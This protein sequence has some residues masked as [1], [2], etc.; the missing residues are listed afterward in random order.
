M[1]LRNAFGLLAVAICVS[2]GAAQ[3][4]TSSSKASLNADAVDGTWRIVTVETVRSMG[5]THAKWLGV[6]PD[7]WIMYN[8]AGHMSVQLM[9]DPRPTL[10]KAGCRDASGQGKASA[11][12]GYCADFG[13]YDLDMNPGTI[14]HHVTGRL[15]PHEVGRQ[16][17]RQFELAEVRLVLTT[18][19]FDEEGEKR[20]DRLVWE[21]AK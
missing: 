8:T 11:F 4:S 3:A 16:L 2:S 1:K 12:D 6:R 9:R 13:T 15:R 5:G 18:P 10:A 20:F 21:R 17:T 19:L 7:G 14:A